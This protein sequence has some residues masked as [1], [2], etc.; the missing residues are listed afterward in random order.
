MMSDSKLIQMI[1]RGIA[2][3]L[4]FP[5]ISRA[6]YSLLK[7]ADQVINIEYASSLNE[8]ARQQ[9]HHWL[10]RVTDALRTVYGEWPN[11]SFGITIKRSSSRGSPVPWGEVNRGD[12][13]TVLLVINP[14]FDFETLLKDWTAYHELSHLLIPY[15]G[16]GDLWFS[17]GLATYYQNIIQARNGVISEPDLWNKIASGFDRGHKQQQWPNI[18]LTEVSEN[19][20]RYGNYMRVHWSGVHYWLT[21]DLKLRRHSQNKLTLDTLLKKLK[22]CCENQSMSAEALAGKLDQLA[23]MD[24]FMPMFIDYRDSY[25]MP[26]YTATLLELGVVHNIYNDSISL[27]DDAPNAQIR[28]SIYKGGL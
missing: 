27:T 19:M 3:L 13:T 26:D 8:E 18:T 7:H 11:D 16:Y 2:L 20:Y 4:I 1:F 23:D 24:M 6:D 10:Q 9:T 5:A 14:A 12:P 21:A 25:A 15:R 28:K 22:T 17:E